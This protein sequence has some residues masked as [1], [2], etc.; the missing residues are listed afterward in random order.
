VTL[1]ST[2]TRTATIALAAAALAAP[3]AL[4]RAADPS[5]AVLKA[6]AALAA[7][8]GPT[9]QVSAIVGDSPADFAQPVAPAFTV[10]DTPSDH[11]G[12]SRAPKDDPP[13]TIQVVRPERTIVRNAN[14]ALP[15]LL[16]GLALLVALGGAGFAL[17]RTR[18]LQRGVVG[19]SH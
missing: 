10:G 13:A 17:V 9:Q 19:R 14:Q 5:E 12:M 16:A 8:D 18:S 2:F 7:P 15:T 3:S 1:R 6:A 4:A 11:P